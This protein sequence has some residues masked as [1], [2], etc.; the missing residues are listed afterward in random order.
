MNEQQKI[1]IPRNDL[2]IVRS[3]QT[4]LPISNVGIGSVIKFLRND[5]LNP[6]GTGSVEFTGLEVYTKTLFAKGES[7]NDVISDT[8]A[9][10]I[11][12]TLV[13][14][15]VEFIKLFPYTGLISQAN[16]GMIRRLDRVKIDLT[17][18]YITVLDSGI[19]ANTSCIFNWFFL[20][21]GT[22]PKRK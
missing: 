22:A 2:A 5:V 10:K 3:Y 15:D 1:I 14:K 11:A 19:P 13:Y 6:N 21:P 8:D 20:E 16:F 12:L 18:S 7:G 9:P 17:K 4:E